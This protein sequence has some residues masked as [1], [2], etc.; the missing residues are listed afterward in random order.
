M[1]EGGGVVVGDEVSITIEAELIQ[2]APADRPEIN[3]LHLR[4]PWRRMRMR[5]MGLPIRPYLVQDDRK[6][7]PK[8][9]RQYSRQWK[10]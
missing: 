6:F 5:R 3:A 10:N 2:K 4:L 7:L 9:N 8:K 1:I